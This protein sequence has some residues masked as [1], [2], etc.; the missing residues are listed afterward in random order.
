MLSGVECGVRKEFCRNTF[1]MRMGDKIFD[2]RKN[3]NRFYPDIPLR[4]NRKLHPI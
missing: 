1:P 2:T 4:V 3:E